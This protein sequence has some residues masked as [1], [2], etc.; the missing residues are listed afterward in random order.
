MVYVKVVYFLVSVVLFL[1][2]VSGIIL[3][4]IDPIQNENNI[5]KKNIL[6]HPQRNKRFSLPKFAKKNEKKGTYHWIH[7]QEKNIK[8]LLLPILKKNK[9][10][11]EKQISTNNSKNQIQC[12]DYFDLKLKTDF[13]YEYIV[14][15]YL[16]NT[17]FR[18]IDFRNRIIQWE[19]YAGDH[20]FETPSLGNFTGITLSGQNEIGFGSIEEIDNA[21][22]VTILFY[23]C[24][25]PE[26]AGRCPICHEIIE[27]KPIYGSR[28]YNWSNTGE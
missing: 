26:L 21:L 12:C 24:P 22:A 10:I 5:L 28:V 13:V 19:T 2:I 14:D 7:N 25:V 6:Q 15:D 3:A 9:E 8:I 23:Q 17:P 20:I 4:I 1:I 16:S 11:Q 27:L 18:V